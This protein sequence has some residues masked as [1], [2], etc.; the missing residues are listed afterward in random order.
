MSANIKHSQLHYCLF[1]GGFFGIVTGLAF[2]I[3][4]V[5]G[6][7]IPLFVIGVFMYFLGYRPVSPWK[8]GGPTDGSAPPGDVIGGD[9]G[10]GDG[11]G[12]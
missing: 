1:L 7:S 4:S 2:E 11:G 5:L 3:E 10:G 8:P 12:D 9:F 6:I